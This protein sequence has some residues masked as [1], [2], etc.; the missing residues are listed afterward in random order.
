[1]YVYIDEIL[2]RNKVIL[3]KI[4]ANKMRYYYFKMNEEFINF[5]GFYP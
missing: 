3:I 5:L 2:M 4:D 1:M